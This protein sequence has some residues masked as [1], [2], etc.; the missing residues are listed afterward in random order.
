MRVVLLANNLLGAKMAHWLVR[1]EEDEIV[2]LVVH[3]EEKSVARAEIIEAV[4]LSRDSIFSA[5]RLQED[6]VLQQ[7]RKVR[8]DIAVSVMFGYILRQSFLEIFPAGC[9]NLHP[10]FLPFN[11]G[12]YPNVWTIVDRTPGG[13]TLHYVDPGID[14][15]DIIAQEEVPV[16]ATDTGKSLYERLMHAGFD[17]FVREWPIIRKQ[18]VQRRPQDHDKATFHR[19]RDVECIDEIDLDETYTARKLL[20]VLRARTYPPHK[21]AYFVENGQKIFIELA[22]HPEDVHD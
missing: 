1:Q 9:I 13:V 10:S 19:V 6:S 14:T 16:F 22:L 18:T 7:I 17:L 3:P 4:G 21:G 12:A 11:R 15:G 20:D 2:G 8:A 5:P